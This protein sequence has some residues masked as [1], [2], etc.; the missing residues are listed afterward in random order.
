[1]VKPSYPAPVVVKAKL[2][3]LG[4]SVIFLTMIV[5]RSRVTEFP[6]VN[7]NVPVVEPITIDAGVNVAV[8]HVNPVI[9]VNVASLTEHVL[10]VGIPDTV[11]EPPFF[12]IIQPVTAVAPLP[13]TPQL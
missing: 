1:M 9:G 6:T 3:V 8:A 10:P 7:V 4:G 12:L 11:A 2:P 13:Y 5:P